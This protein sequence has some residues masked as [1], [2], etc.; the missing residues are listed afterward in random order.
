MYSFIL[1]IFFFSSRRRH[2]ICALVTG[3]QTCALPIFADEETGYSTQQ[4][5]RPQTLG[6]G[7]AD[8]PVGQAAWIYEKFNAWTDCAGDPANV[9]T[10]DEMLDN[11]MLYWLPDRKSKRLNSSH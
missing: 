9:L 4:R 11:I 1:C 5:T 7:L 6:Y 10:F 3:V 2:T 8:S